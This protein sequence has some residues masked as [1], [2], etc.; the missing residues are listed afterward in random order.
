MAPSTNAYASAP[1]VSPAA[2]DYLARMFPDGNAALDGLAKTD[3]EFAERFCNFA[4][5]QVIAEGAPDGEPLD[6]RTRFL[7][8][9]ATLIG[10]QG[11]DEFRTMLPAALN[12]GVDAIAA[13]EVV[14]Q[15][16][17]YLGMG[18]IAPFLTAFDDEMRARGIDLPLPNQARNSTDSTERTATGE[19]KQVEFFGEGMRGFADAGNPE[20]PQINRWLASNCFG[21]W[22]TRGGLDGRERELVTFCYLAA[23]GGCEPQLTSHARANMRIGNDKALLLKVVSANV[24]WIG[25]P[26][27]LNAIRCIEDAAQ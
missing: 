15:A 7:S 16:T 24:P 4:F 12:A 20:Y 2:R 6:S 23:Q 18:R 13:R 22:Y 9:L 1:N 21:D 26:R 19:A 10:C 14:Y 11:I 27:S 5:D 3:P 25:Y 8:L 17:A